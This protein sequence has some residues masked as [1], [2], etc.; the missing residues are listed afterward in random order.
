MMSRP[1]KTLRLLDADLEI[2]VHG[3][4][5]RPGSLAARIKPH[6]FEPRLIGTDLA[7]DVLVTEFEPPAHPWAFSLS[8]V[9]SH[10]P[11]SQ[12]PHLR[13]DRTL[14][15]SSAK[16]HALCVYSAAEFTFDPNRPLIPQFLDQVAIFLAKHVIWLKTQG[17]FG[18][19]GRM[20]HDGSD[21]S[22]IM[23]AIPTSAFL[24]RCS[25]QSD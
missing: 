25:T 7:F 22:T 4:T 17:L 9:I 23:S 13:G 14:Q 12:H 5:M 2:P 16:L 10:S 6:A 20:L 19:D 11:Q 18:S 24:E 3:G 1:G 21:M 8:P 15:L